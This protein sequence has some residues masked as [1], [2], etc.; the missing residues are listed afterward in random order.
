MDE[1]APGIGRLYRELWRFSEG[2]R[3]QLVAS[4]A[5]LI[6]S[7]LAKLVVPAL[8]GTAINTIQSQGIAGAGRAGTLLALVFGA[9]AVS[10]LLHGPGRILERNVALVVRQKLSTE[11]MQR[12]FS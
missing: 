2:H 7:Q 1:S 4:F 6:G 5:L 10:W 3:V 11:L 8:A 12:L 9:T